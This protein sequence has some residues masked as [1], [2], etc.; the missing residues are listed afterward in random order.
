[1]GGR[2]MP[3]FWLS[4]GELYMGNTI[5]PPSA[6][7]SNNPNRWLLRIRSLWLGIIVLMA[8]AFL[9]SI[10]STYQ[11]LNSVCDSSVETCNDWSQPTTETVEALQHYHIPLKTAA[12]YHL[13]LYVIVSLI[14]W[15]AGLLVL[16]HRSR[17]WHG[18]LVSYL[19]IAIGAGGV[20]LVF[21]SE[22]PS[23]GLT[24]ALQSIAGLTIMPL[25]LAMSL[26]F[27]TFP[28]GR[29]YPRWT[30]LVTLL[31][32]ANYGVWLAPGQWNI[33]QWSP[34]W[35]AIWILFVFGS[36][37]GVQGFRY[38]FY[39]TKE[40]RQQTK[41]LIYGFSMVLVLGLVVL[42]NNQPLFD[43]L[44]EGT[45]V[46]L[47]YLPIAIAITIAILRYQLWDIDIII[48]RT[49][50]YAVLTSLVI[51]V[52]IVIVGGFSAVFEASGDL[53][54]SLLATAV[55]A[56]GFQPLRQRVQL[57]VNR[58]T[59]GDRDEPYKVISRLG[60]RLESTIE[61]SAVLPTIVETVSQALKLPYAAIALRRNG[62]L[63]VVAEYGIQDDREIVILPLN[64]ASQMLGELR[65]A[66]RSPHEPLTR[67]D[68]ILLDDL[69]RQAGVAI[70]AVL[71]NMDL[72]LSRQ[73]IVT[74]R[75][76]ARRRLGSDLH[77]SIGHRLAAVLRKVDLA[78]R[79]L[80]DDYSAVN[81]L[82]EDIRD[83]L[84][85]TINEVRNL[86]HTLYPP[87][88]ELLGLSGALRESIH[89]YY[90]TVQVNLELPGNLARL[91]LAIEV[92]AY[93]I[94]QE[95]MTNISRHASA[96][97]CKISLRL[98]HNHE[99]VLHIDIQDDGIGIPSE[100]HRIGLGLT[101]MKRRATELGGSFLI[102]PSPDGGTHI[103]V[104]IPCL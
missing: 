76:E 65:L 94:V 72:Q 69:A 34:I 100:Q 71:L 96:Q 16:R 27:L 97:S 14:F 25:Y 50:V 86:A 63:A 58:L 1:M 82:L 61:Q 2:T 91:P 13:T 80:D 48:N 78:S 5:V 101:S 66:L 3:P 42:S 20:S 37:V 77:D 43:S 56:I 60:R 31:I 47:L 39:Y 36:H 23:D 55:V 38:Y 32:L 15:G 57:G 26:F 73:Q 75:E 52:Y 98:V 81:P 33:Q 95:A 67:K 18:I 12:I 64:Y 17:D 8:F 21:V 83:Q 40:Q 51:S 92:A 89:Q 70:H 22:T 11:R 46:A 103:K 90:D 68:E 88:L 41:W 93:Y 59:F 29:I 53:P 79:D 87:E 10:P 9:S 6:Q 24:R 19:L 45:L 85:G 74:E 84:R 62:S 35:S 102:V 44:A 28:D 99:S 7:I 104:Q 4:I 30:P 54:G 49:L